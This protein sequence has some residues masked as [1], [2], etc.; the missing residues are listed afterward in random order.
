MI[1]DT[2][3]LN[4]AKSKF[5][6]GQYLY[7][8]PC[9]N[10]DSIYE[11]IANIF[12]YYKDSLPKAKESRIL[13]KPNLNSN[14]NSLTGNTTD[15]RILAAVIYN[16]SERGYT[17]IIVGEGTSS[18]FYRNKINVAKRL[19]VLNLITHYKNVSFLDFNYDDKYPILFEDSVEAYVAKTCIESDFFINIPKIKTHFEAT[20]TV[21]LKSLIGCLTGLNEKQKTHF[22][23]YKNIIHLNEYI[24][25]D[26][27]IVDGLISMEGTGPSLGT[28]IRTDSLLAGRDP[29]LLDMLCSKIASIDYDRIPV[30][31]LA[32][33]K[34]YITSGDLEIYDAFKPAKSFKFKEPSP[35]FIAKLINNQKWQKYFILLRIG[36]LN[37]FFN[38]GSVGR[39]LNM[40]GLRQDV[41]NIEDQNIDTIFANQ[42]CNRCNI[43]E[44]YCPM[45]LKLEDLGCRDK[46]CISCLYCYFICPK[47]AISLSGKLGFLSE[48]INS[49]DN[50]TR[51][52]ER[53]Q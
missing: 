37:E 25:P 2:M 21:C 35:T 12:N 22:S 14:M 31:R 5:E 38:I 4:N 20:M 32:K 48:Q 19:C 50:L 45:R 52:L 36:I 29:F 9:R 42:D 43:C 46:G 53:N 51:E 33:A 1:G 6:G 39:L 30:L 40:T 44:R 24:H 8:Y 7:Y 28:P 3:G 49:Y 34:G 17:N 26:L 16:L 18:G 27:T 13:I 23:L 41:F 10:V 15:L 47:K 11:N